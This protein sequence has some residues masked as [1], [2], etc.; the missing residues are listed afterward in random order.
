MQLIE[1]KFLF[2][3]SDLMRFS[4]CTHA[5]FLD[6]ARLEGHGPQPRADDEEAKLLQEMGDAH[7][8]AHLEALKALGRHVVEVPREGLSLE[9]GLAETRKALASGADV[10]FQAALHGGS[11]GGW[12]D[13]LERVERSSDLGDWSYEVTDTKLKRKPDPKHLL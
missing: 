3:A 12:S 1:G 13:F 9:S 10:I 2:S 7:E 8:A 5:T 11:W 4:G 6:L